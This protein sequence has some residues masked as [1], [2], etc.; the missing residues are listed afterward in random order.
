MK[1]KKKRLISLLFKEPHQKAIRNQWKCI[2]EEYRPIK[3]CKGISVCICLL[4]LGHSFR[5]STTNIRV[6]P[7]A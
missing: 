3:E 6:M 1:K 5:I 2:G 7:G 4:T